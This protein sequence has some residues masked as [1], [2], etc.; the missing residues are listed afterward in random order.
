M[1]TNNSWTFSLINVLYK[2]PTVFAF[3][4]RNPT[5]PMMEWGIHLTIVCDARENEPNSGIWTHF[6]SFRAVIGCEC[7]KHSKPISFKSQS[8]EKN[9][10]F[11]LAIWKYY[12]FYVNGGLLWRRL[13]ECIITKHA[14]TVNVVFKWFCILYFTSSSMCTQHSSCKAWIIECVVFCPVAHGWIIS[15]ELTTFFTVQKPCSSWE[16]LY[17]FRAGWQIII[18]SYSCVMTKLIWYILFSQ[19]GMWNTWGFC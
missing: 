11:H 16:N 6:S 7:W 14:L 12:V 17:M 18:V 13:T 8:W 1:V 15:P 19:H 5:H 2:N 3:K 4:G 9:A 10:W